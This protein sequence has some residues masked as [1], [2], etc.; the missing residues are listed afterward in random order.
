MLM[1]VNKKGAKQLKLCDYCLKPRKIFKNTSEGSQCMSCWKHENAVKTLIEKK[2]RKS[3]KNTK[4]VTRELLDLK[5]SLYIRFLHSVMGPTNQRFVKCY[6]CDRLMGIKDAQ[7]GH[8]VKREHMYTRWLSDNCRPQC[9]ECNEIK[10][11]NYE[12]FKRRLE[13]DIPGI[14]EQLE[15]L[16][17]KV[18]TPTEKDMTELADNIDKEMPTIARS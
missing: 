16:G 3:K 5:F 9:K 1:G 14:T 8:Y 12:I 4:T 2:D 13:R 6:T 17:R 15:E 18:W 7:C 11:G 10:G